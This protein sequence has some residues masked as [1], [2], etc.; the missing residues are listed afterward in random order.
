MAAVDPGETDMPDIP[1]TISETNGY[2]RVQQARLEEDQ[3]KRVRARKT[4]YGNFASTSN[5]AQALGLSTKQE[6]LDYLDLGEGWSPYIPRDP[7]GYYTERGEWL[8][9]SFWLTGRPGPSVLSDE[10]HELF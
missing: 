9:W 8:G 7:E 5:Y 4:R 2:W 6:W 10:E 3:A 1:D